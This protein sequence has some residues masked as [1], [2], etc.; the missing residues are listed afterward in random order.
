MSSNKHY[1]K[2]NR[3]I[4][5][6]GFMILLFLYCAKE[7]NPFNDPTNARVHILKP[8]HTADTLPIFT[9][10]SVE[11]LFTVCNLIEK[12]SVKAT[13]N[14]YFD[15][16]VF[17][18]VCFPEG[19]VSLP[20]SFYDTGYQEL[21]V[22][23]HLIDG[24]PLIARRHYYVMSRLK[25]D[26]IVGHY[27]NIL[28][29]SA[30][31]NNPD[32]DHDLW[33]IWK[34]G[35]ETVESPDST[36]SI[37]IE[38]PLV[39]DKC[40]LTICDFQKRY[41]SPPVYFRIVLSDTV[42]PEIV[43]Q[44]PISNDTIYVPG[45][46]L[47]LH[48]KIKKSYGTTT[49]YANG[50]IMTG[51]GSNSFVHIISRADKQEMLIDIVADAGLGKKSNRVVYVVFNS[52]ILQY[53][54]PLI[55]VIGHPGDEVINIQQKQYN[56][57]GRI[58][59]NANNVMK[60]SVMLFKVDQ[61]VDELV[62]SMSHSGKETFHWNFI[63]DLA[64]ENK[65]DIFYRLELRDSLSNVIDKK[66]VSI[67]YCANCIDSVPPVIASVLVNNDTLS[68]YRY[69]SNSRDVS[70]ELICFDLGSGVD[71]VL[72]GNEIM[73]P[74]EKLSYRWDKK[75]EVSHIL[76][77]DT[78][79]FYTV[80]LNGNRSDP[81]RIVVGYNSAPI[82][83]VPPD[84]ICHAFTGISY[85]DTVVVVDGDPHD[86]VK[87]SIYFMNNMTAQSTEK[88]L[89]DQYGHISWI[90]DSSHLG[91]NHVTVVGTDRNGASVSFTYR[92]YVSSEALEPVTFLT[93]GNDFPKTLTCTDS[94]IVPL[95]VKGGTGLVKIEIAE[96][97]SNGKIKIN[98]SDTVFRWKPPIVEQ[99]ASYQF[100]IVA[101]DILGIADTLWPVVT[102]LPENRPFEVVEKKWTGK[103][104]SD[105]I[106]DLSGIYTDT[107]FYT[108]DDPDSAL[109]EKYTIVI[110]S[111]I[112]KYSISTDS[113]AF[114]IVLD[115][116]VKRSGADM[117]QVTITDNGGHVKKIKQNLYYGS[118]PVITLKTPHSDT[119]VDSKTVHFGWSGT[120]P[121]SDGLVY[122]FSLLFNGETT[123]ENRAG[124]YDTFVNLSH[125]KKEGIYYW[126]VLVYDNKS[127]ESSTGRFYYTPPD[128]VRFDTLHSRLPSLIRCADTIRAPLTI[129]NGYPPFNINVLQS[130]Q[131]N[132]PQIR[133]DS[134]IWAPDCFQTGRHLIMLE[135]TD[136]VGNKDV[137]SFHT[138]VY[139]SYSLTVSLVNTVPRTA[140]GEIDLSNVLV[141]EV[142]CTLSI[143]DPDPSPPD[144]FIIEVMLGNVRQEFFSKSVDRLITLSL[145]SDP[146][147]LRDVLSVK[148]TEM[149]GI[150]STYVDSIYYGE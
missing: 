81:M 116:L 54:N 47:Q 12:I 16:T 123:I 66:T 74:D 29:L 86:H 32:Q 149:K 99:A 93:S 118:P 112:E 80:D 97:S 33:Y 24:E 103:K 52:S 70:I 50:T 106:L 91:F 34:I 68:A 10:D 39:D 48:L 79:V 146:D 147:K 6:S 42:K 95:R 134:I 126:S 73:T 7:Y 3:W 56:L 124:I 87:Y 78:L 17:T 27:G 113:P 35:N 131:T 100:F 143:N 75:L 88:L 128:K 69:V 25:Q 8:D 94:L 58:V 150:H 20:V 67:Q 144:S 92:I 142:V 77:P 51:V 76:T 14:R 55:D 140:S 111:G 85:A 9:T 139:G 132:K 96:V 15:D 117:V 30:D 71:S 44:N 107:L 129:S 63:L 18:N 125:L 136:A 31:Q 135:V 23:T 57:N 130:V 64:R 41:Y 53:V 37:T 84:S 115:P 145:K 98:N 19:K 104:W 101:K 5:L 21:S 40:I 61:S 43:V 22:V 110:E 4:F 141:K 28:E 60:Y 122:D 89:I 2:I 45:D 137:F 36:D 26:D 114:F 11:L 120:D 65:K 1:F 38:E 105:A 82:I 138:S 127:S 13:N 102:I 59:F 148:V 108:I 109:F 121:D 90:P 83:K 119:V 133:N 49:V 46:T 72:I 62:D